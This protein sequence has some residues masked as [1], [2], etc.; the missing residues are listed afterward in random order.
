M[1][2]DVGKPFYSNF[3]TIEVQKICMSAS[4]KYA[5]PLFL[6][7]KIKEKLK[8]KHFM[9][10]MLSMEKRLGIIQYMHVCVLICPLEFCFSLVIFYTVDDD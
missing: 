1:L 10:N 4:L 9:F 7:R 5:E 6:E 2:L 8:I 3:L